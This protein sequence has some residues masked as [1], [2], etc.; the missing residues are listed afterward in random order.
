MPTAEAQRSIGQLSGESQ[1]LEINLI[2][3]DFYVTMPKIM[4]CSTDSN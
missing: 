1:S 3:G 2:E 4:G